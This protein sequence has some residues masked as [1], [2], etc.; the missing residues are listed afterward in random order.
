MRFLI[1]LIIMIV[2]AFPAFSEDIKAEGTGKTRA[3]ALQNADDALAQ[4][5]ALTTISRTKIIDAD[6]GTDNVS[7]MITAIHSSYS[8][9]FL[10]AE[11]SIEEHEGVF[12]ATRIIPESSIN[13]YLDRI[14]DSVSIINN[15]YETIAKDGI[16]YE[17][18][19]RIYAQLREYERYSVIVSMLDDD[20]D[21]P[22]VPTNSADIEAMYQNAL[23]VNL[24][25]A[26]QSVDNLEMQE[27]LGTISQLGRKEL[28]KALEDLDRIQRE[29]SVLRL[30]Q[31]KEA[32]DD[33]RAF[34]KSQRELVESLS[35]IEINTE[36][37]ASPA[38][39][40]IRR[41][42]GFM[43]AYNFAKNGIQTLFSNYE[44][45]YEDEVKAAEESIRAEEYLPFERNSL[46]RVTDAAKEVREAEIRDA[47]KEILEEY[48]ATAMR[49]YNLA[50]QELISISQRGQNAMRNLTDSTFS[51][52]SPSS[53]LSTRILGF[54][55]G[56]NRWVGEAVLTI[57]TESIRI[58]FYISLW[59]W[60]GIEHDENDTYYAYRDEVNE[61]L[62]F[63]TSYSYAYILDIDYSVKCYAGDSSCH[64]VITSVEV[65]RRDNNALLYSSDEQYEMDLPLSH[66]AEFVVYVP[67]S[68]LFDTS[69]AFY[70][71]EKVSTLYS[72]Y[73]S[74]DANGERERIE[75]RKAAE[76]R[77]IEERKKAEEERLERQRAEEERRAKE[78][79]RKEEEARKA[80][81]AQLEAQLREQKL[82]EFR[83][84]TING[85]SYLKDRNFGTP[86][87]GFNVLM[88]KFP[89]STSPY[90][91]NPMVRVTFNLDFWNY[92]G[93]L[94]PVVD[95][96]ILPKQNR[97]LGGAA[98]A[99][100]IYPLQEMVGLIF[101]ARLG[102]VY[103]ENIKPVE[104]IY[105]NLSLGAIMT[106][107]MANTETGEE[108][109]DIDLIVKVGGAYLFNKLWWSVDVGAGFV[110]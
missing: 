110:F 14:R 108:V 44:A 91:I 21:I 39:S 49:N 18:Y 61:L 24:N 41:I 81:M 11:Y 23:V 34:S 88:D 38:L 75:E 90:T 96:L 52:T 109:F 102:G 55:L 31:K 2:M 62:N 42:E 15:L 26:Q 47:R 30:A 98:G 8:T 95:L 7:Y 54:D 77:R 43:Q 1:A 74:L 5:I 85:I 79:A 72:S 12:T 103:F 64:I 19:Q 58:P 28:E 9:D 92:R 105:A 70:P 53:E 84:S 76:E 32:E 57:G 66:Y 83:A 29:Q 87:V 60:L 3:E 16:T 33:L 89:N 104:A 46:G 78:A 13:L 27:E 63:L 106:I 65:R 6:D 71:E 94:R 50:V 37:A 4:R 56:D 10:G 51:I 80:A 20:M 107:P 99:D 17:T 68:K 97:A 67:S 36:S 101:S 82:A 86:E 73:W 22:S 48:Q 45:R 59:D 25:K 40:S 100:F 35:S 93:S 69:S